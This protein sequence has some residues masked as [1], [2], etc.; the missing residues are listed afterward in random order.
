MFL[1]GINYQCVVI[2]NI[3]TCTCNSPTEGF[4]IPSVGG[5]EY[6]FFMELHNIKLMHQ[7]M[8]SGIECRFLSLQKLSNQGCMYNVKS[9]SQE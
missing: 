5:G 2:E 8:H 3:H 1:I 4:S 6:G 9:R 7:S